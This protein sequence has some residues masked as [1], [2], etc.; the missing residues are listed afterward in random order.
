LIR[1]RYPAYKNAGIE[2]LD[3]I[4]SSW[5]VA[6]IKL[7][8]QVTLGKMLQSEPSGPADELRPYLR[9][10]HIPPGGFTLDDPKQ[11]W[12]TPKESNQL[13]LKKGDVVVV[14]G[15]MGGY[16]RCDIVPEDVPGWGFQNSINRLR[17]KGGNIGA[18]TKY[19]LQSARTNG[20]LDV[21][22]SVSTM[23][24]LTVEKLGAIR[25]PLPTVSEQFE[26]ARFLDTETA[27]IDAL[28]AKQ[29][30]LID[31]LLEDRAST[32]TQA[33][34]KGIDAHVRLIESGVAWLGA[35]PRHWKV[36]QSRRLFS[37]RRTRAQPDDDQLTASQKYG[38]IPQK[39]FMAREGAQVT[40][41]ILNPEIL[42]HVE[43][44]DFVISMRSFQGGIEYSGHAGAV[45]SAYVP[46]TPKPVVHA[47]FFRY[48]LKSTT[49][50]Q[51]LQSTSNLVRD[52]QALR[53]ENFSMV[54][55]PLLPVGEQRDIAAFLSHRC[56][57]IDALIAKAEQVIETLREYRS[58]LITDA[59][60]GKIDVRGAA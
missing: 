25:L 24:H 11:M 56:N 4:P 28:I 9:A 39:E 54:P 58:A 18:Y 21:L 7:T 3:D 51:A 60:T 1:S 57:K 48:L 23:P 33:V 17:P 16:G 55:L 30:L 15:G 49:Y 53:F 8:H 29:D 35:I 26:I 38:V 22:C 42:K 13:N 5:G 2:W 31:T 37:Q 47:D 40:Q 36:I 14:E 10:A 46:L 45:S 43:P 44:G 20:Y 19:A 50:I 59:V 52:G 6:A 34:T 32:I 41:V 12:F 27:I